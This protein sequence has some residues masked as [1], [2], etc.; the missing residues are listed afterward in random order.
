MNAKRN[1]PQRRGPI[2]PQSQVSPRSPPHMLAASAGRPASR[3][4]RRPTT[5][6]DGRH[7]RREVAFGKEFSRRSIND[8]CRRPPFTDVRTGSKYCFIYNFYNTRSVASVRN[9]TTLMAPESLVINHYAASQHTRMAARRLAPH[10]LR[11]SLKRIN[12]GQKFD[13]Q[14][15]V[16]HGDADR[17]AD[18]GQHGRARTVVLSRRAAGSVDGSVRSPS[19]CRAGRG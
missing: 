12:E 9:P 19:D 7:M 17:R 1:S 4:R 16:R 3:F 13:A 18:D 5:A 2:R 8:G 15:D 11:R 10:L 14:P 6:V